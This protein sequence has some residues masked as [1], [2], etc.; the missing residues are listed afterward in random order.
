MHSKQ[1]PVVQSIISSTSSLRGKLVMCFT[2]LEANTLLFFVF[3]K[4][5]EAFHI[6][7]T[8]NLGFFFQILVSE[9]LTNVT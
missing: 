8:K 2:T 6:F 5:R 3:Q 7:S 4:M 9:I 1:G